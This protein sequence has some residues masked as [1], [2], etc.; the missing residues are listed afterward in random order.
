LYH[1]GHGQVVHGRQHP[2]KIFWTLRHD[3]NCLD[4]V[5]VGTDGR[6]Y[7]HIGLP[8]AVVAAL[9]GAMKGK[10]YRPFLMRRP[11]FGNENLIFEMSGLDRNGAVDEPRLVFFCVGR[12]RNQ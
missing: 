9:A 2:P 8:Q 7:S 6:A 11:I 10:N 1:R 3:Y 5:A 4:G 12:K